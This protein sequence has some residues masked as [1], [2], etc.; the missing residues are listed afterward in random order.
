M[1]DYIK[2]ILLKRWLRKHGIKLSHGMTVIPKKGKLIMEEGVSIHAESMH[3]GE[4]A[5]GAMTYVR[6]GSELLNVRRIGRFCS[7]S[8]NVVIGQHKGG[9]GHPLS[10][11]STHPFQLDAV[12]PPPENPPVP[13]TTLGHDVWIGRDA[14]IMEGVT[15]GTGAVI[16]SRA[17]V[18]RDIPEY[19]IVAGAPARVIRYR[20]PPELV[21]ELL[22]SAWWEM[23]VD[24]LKQLPLGKPAEFLQ[25][26]G[27]F[28]PARYKRCIVT[29]STWTLS[30][31]DH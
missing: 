19:A 24:D 6:S 4:L 31:P 21:R 12:T 15:V 16:A 20:H 25:H 18:T 14:M 10:W 26:L 23:H 3:F 9:R 17:L 22:A 11:V 5:V 1:I 27:Q 2:N 28:M 7:I 30:L 8:N 29:R 13:G